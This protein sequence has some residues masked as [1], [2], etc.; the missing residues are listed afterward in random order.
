MFRTT[1]LHF[2]NLFDVNDYDIIDTFISKFIRTKGESES[3]RVPLN[4]RTD[5]TSVRVSVIR[6]RE[7]RRRSTAGEAEQED[8]DATHE[9]SVT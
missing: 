9:V 6:S 5:D 2:A 3:A 4:F 7:F 1:L 8:Q